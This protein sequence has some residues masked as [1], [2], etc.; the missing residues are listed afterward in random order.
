MLAPCRYHD[1]LPDPTCTPGLTEYATTRQVC[2]PGFSTVRR[3]VTYVQ[4]RVVFA[5]YGVSYARRRYY[6]FD[7]LIPLEL[8][9]SNDTLNLWPEPLTH[10][11][12][13]DRIEDRLHYE[14]CH[15]RLS[16]R[17]AQRRIAE[18]WVIA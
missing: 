6:Q 7:H 3:H 14:V 1:V 17:V 10:A 4:R 2:T 11:H 13:K 18:N 9:G 15:T 12:H 16:L 5:R 8:A